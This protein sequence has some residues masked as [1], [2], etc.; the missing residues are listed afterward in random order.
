[1]RH[2]SDGV[3][4]NKRLATLIL[5]S[6]AEESEEHRS[7]LVEKGIGSLIIPFIPSGNIGLTTA[8]IRTLAILL[9][10]KDATSAK[11][12][13]DDAIPLLVSLVETGI[14]AQKFYAALALGT[15]AEDI[16][17]STLIAAEGAIPLYL[18]RDGDED[19]KEHAAY[20]LAQLAN[21][22]T[23]GPLIVASCCSCKRRK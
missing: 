15:L 17:N 4:E 11:L 21:S 2:L 23:N 18:V 19:E 13:R 20:A 16:E 8:A 3:E 5:G 10:S 7:L 1:M 6:L 22:A 12:A 9:E 14:E